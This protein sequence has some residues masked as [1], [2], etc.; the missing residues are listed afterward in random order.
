MA[1]INRKT[2]FSY[3]RRAPFG[4]KLSQS[5]V[6]GMNEILDYWES[7]NYTDI[8]WLA[9]MLAQTYHETAYTMQP[10]YEKGS[11]SYFN[12]YDGRKDLGNTVIGDG[13]KFRGRGLIQITGRKN[14]TLLGQKLGV[15]LVNNPDLALQPDIAVEIMFLGMT[16][17]L[18]TGKKLSDYFNDTTDDPRNARR[19]VNGTDKAGLIA[20]YHTN[21]LGTL[22]RA[23]QDVEPDDVSDN[24]ALPD[25]PNLLKDTSTIGA[26]IAGAGAVAGAAGDLLSKIDN[27]WSLTALGF[28]IIGLGVFY[29]GRSQIAKHKGV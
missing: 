4:G 6:E 16:E 2:F 9:N 7:Q 27:I 5:Q 25:K 28:A 11:K 8:R 20:G 24:E 29:F 3:I 12:K 15:D 13:Y 23:M 18:F 14:Y 21:F 19:I 22:E 1:K 17:G 26:L 10:V